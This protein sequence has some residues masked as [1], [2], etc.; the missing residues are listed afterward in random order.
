KLAISYSSVF[1]YLRHPEFIERKGRSDRG[2][3][4]LD[5]YKDYISQQ[6]NQ[7]CY[8]AKKLFEELK[9]Q[10]YSGSYDTVARYTRRL[11]QATGMELRQRIID[12][13]LPQ[14]VEPLK[15]SL[16]PRK[17]TGLVMQKV[18][19]LD[20]NDQQLIKLLKSRSSELSEAIELTQDFTT[21]VR[22]RNPEKLD[23]WLERA[24]NS[25]ISPLQSFALRLQGDY[26][27]VKA[28][29][30]FSVSNGPVEGQINRLKMLKRQM[31][32][33]AGID[34]LSR[35]FLIKI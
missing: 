16:T 27:C 20:A 29:V 13:P 33:R 1:R 26:A 15:C 32:G 35:R 34:L 18:S 31:Y 12:K 8:E 2:C 30:T 22:Q 19:R 9:K 7:K 6:W 10:G 14:V 17:A 28:A 4:K 21:I 3:S 11:R 5:P 25:N 23:A 24:I